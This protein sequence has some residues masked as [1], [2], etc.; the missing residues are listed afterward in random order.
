MRK[1]EERFAGA[2]NVMWPLTP[3]P[4]STVRSASTLDPSASM[5]STP[6]A[7][8]HL[9]LWLRR[10]MRSV[11]IG[12]CLF[13]VALLL[14]TLSSGDA[15]ATFTRGGG[16]SAYGAAYQFFGGA[17]S[18][19]SF[20][21]AD[22]VVSGGSEA[23]FHVAAVADLDKRSKHDTGKEWFSIVTPGLLKRTSAGG[24]ALS[25]RPQDDVK[26]FTK[27]NEG[28]RGMELSEVSEECTRVPIVRVTPPGANT[29]R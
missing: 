1:K 3:P 2:A 24:Y 6:G 7:S 23:A 26:L 18:T 5:M 19:G 8:A 15:D 13:S 14:N 9:V 4:A 28:G 21:A 27:H 29:C 11:L 22:S 10:N 12:V 25:W 16:G 20:S 17:V